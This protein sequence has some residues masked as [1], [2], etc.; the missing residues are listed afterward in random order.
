MLNGGLWLNDKESQHLTLHSHSIELRKT[1]LWLGIWAT[2]EED[3]QCPPVE[4]IKAELNK[5]QQINLIIAYEI[6]WRDIVECAQRVI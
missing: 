5:Y 1:M 2:A 4:P 3:V 6:N